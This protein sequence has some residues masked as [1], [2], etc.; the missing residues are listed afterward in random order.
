MEHHRKRIVPYRS[1]IDANPQSTMN[2][3]MKD[4]VGGLYVFG[5][6]VYTASSQDYP[7][8]AA[9]VYLRRVRSPL[10]LLDF[11]LQGTNEVMLCELDPEKTT[12][13]F[14]LI[15][16]ERA[17]TA[18]LIYEA[19]SFCVLASYRSFMR[20]ESIEYLVRAKVLIYIFFF[21]KK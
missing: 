19:T 7:A 5:V 13:V 16:S 21:K 15:K 20:A 9:S 1:M 10:V 6:P 8:A 17:R 3:F 11:S 12:S 14:A 2:T 4:M 18:G